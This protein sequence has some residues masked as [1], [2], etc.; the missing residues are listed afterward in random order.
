[1]II[2][3]NNRIKVDKECTDYFHKEQKEFNS[4]G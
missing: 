2:E 3:K 1:M 4:I